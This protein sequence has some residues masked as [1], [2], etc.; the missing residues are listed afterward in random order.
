[1]TTTQRTTDQPTARRPRRRPRRPGGS[2]STSTIRGCAWSRSMS[3]PPPTTR[4]TS[5]V[6]CCGTSTPTSRTRDYA[7]VDAASSSELVRRSGISADSTVVFYGYAPAMGLWLLELFGHRDVRILNCSRDE[8]LAAGG[9]LTA[10]DRADRAT[11]YV[12]DCRG[13]PDPRGSGRG[14]VGDR[15]SDGHHPGRSQRRRVPRRRLLALRWSR[16][17]RSGRPRAERDPRPDR[18]R[19]R[20]ARPVP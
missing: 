17:R 18:R 2:G 11:G 12:L 9:P 13:R 15:R 10:G 20:R 5:T 4:G 7:T 14:R 1:M 8:W 6:R 3:A 16:A 19:S